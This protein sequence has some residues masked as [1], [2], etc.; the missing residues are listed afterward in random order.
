LG[1]E[2]LDLSPAQGKTVRLLSGKNKIK[3]KNLKAK[4]LGRC[5]P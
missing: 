4:R 2:D 5:C 1:L 3:Q